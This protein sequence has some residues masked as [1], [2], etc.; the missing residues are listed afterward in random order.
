METDAGVA[1]E[2]IQA[3]RNSLA[4]FGAVGLAA[5]AG[6]GR[7][8]SRFAGA[9][10]SA[11]APLVK[12]QRAAFRCALV[13]CVADAQHASL[14]GKGFA[15]AAAAEGPAAPVGNGPAE[16]LSGILSGTGWAAGFDWAAV[17]LEVR[18]RS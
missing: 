18:I 12:R 4:T 10:P 5:A 14:Q 3:G 9:T 17:T 8:P 6:G 15:D 13:M 16:A 1:L 11:A 7:R 2:L